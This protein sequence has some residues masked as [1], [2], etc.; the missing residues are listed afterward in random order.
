MDKIN[1]LKEQLIEKLTN[2]NNNLDAQ[3]KRYILMALTAIIVLLLGFGIVPNVR[4]NIRNKQIHSVFYP[5]L[6]DGENFV[7]A[8]YRGAKRLILDKDEVTLLF[9]DPN[10]KNYSNL[11]KVLQDDKKKSGM[12]EKVYVYPL[13]YD[14]KEMK[15]FFKLTSDVTLIHFSN[16]KEVRRVSFKDPQEIDLYF[17]DHLESVKQPIHPEKSDK[18][19]EETKTSDGEPGKT[20]DAPAEDDDSDVIEDLKNPEAAGK[21]S[22]ESSESIVQ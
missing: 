19:T 5:R 18:K 8:D 10:G 6:V 7:M 16:Q 17:M 12:N 4:A 20:E 13:V 21:E 11:E 15:S 2:L 14:M 9:V 3:K 22:S 1:H